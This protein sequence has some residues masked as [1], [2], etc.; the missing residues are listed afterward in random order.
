MTADPVGTLVRAGLAAA[1]WQVPRVAAA[2]LSRHLGAAGVE[3]LYADHAQRHLSALDGASFPG[4][5][6][7]WPIAADAGGPGAVFADRRDLAVASDGVVAVP[8][9]VR[10]ERVGVLRLRWDAGPPQHLGD[11][12]GRASLAELADALA[13][14]L[15]ADAGT[16]RI[17]R[18]RRSEDFSLSAELQWAQLPAQ[19]VVGASFTLAAHLEPAARVTSDLY[20]WSWSPDGVWFALLDAVGP[21]GRRGMAS[22]QTA[23]LALTALRNARRWGADLAEQAWLADRAVA[24]HEDGESRVVALLAQVD[25]EGGHASVVGAGGPSLLLGEP[26]GRPWEVE[27][28]TDQPP[29]GSGEQ[30]EYR[31]DDVALGPGRWLLAVTDGVLEACGTDGEAFGPG[32]LRDLLDVGGPVVD[33]PRRVVEAVTAHSGS[34]LRDDASAILLART[35]QPG[36]RRGRA[37]SA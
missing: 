15:H 13:L 3:I 19:S 25:V 35:G 28:L 16:D 37:G 23:T 6:A 7:G 9:G 14:L 2:F 5:D 24:D 12:A 4:D 34:E 8:L 29:L 26:R 17:E 36:Q 22:A 30:D 31:C 11:A 32:R 1:P 21:R 27:T 18:W 20:D 10:G 33:V